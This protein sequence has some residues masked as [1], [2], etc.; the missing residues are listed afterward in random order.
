M[1]RGIGQTVRYVRGPVWFYHPCRW[2]S[3]VPD[4]SFAVFWEDRIAVWTPGDV[5]E[6]MG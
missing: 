5:P 4:D 1:R 6:V 3:V 2:F